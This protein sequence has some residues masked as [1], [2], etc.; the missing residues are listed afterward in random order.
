M[1]TGGPQLAQQDTERRDHLPRPA[2]KLHHQRRGIPVKNQPLLLL[3]ETTLDNIFSPIRICISGLGS[4]G[5]SPLPGRTQGRL[6]KRAIGFSPVEERRRARGGT[7]RATSLPIDMTTNS[8]PFET[9]SSESLHG[10]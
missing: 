1:A 2:V 7:S 9:C 3:S 8:S 5:F 4:G 6:R 10:L